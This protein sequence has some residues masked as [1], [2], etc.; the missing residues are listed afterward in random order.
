MKINKKNLF[1]FL[2]LLVIEI[3][4]ALFVHDNFIR[5]FVGDLIVVFLVYYFVKIFYSWNDTKVIIWVFLFAVFVEILQYFKL[6]EVLWI[7][8]RVLQIAIGSTFDIKDIVMYGLWCIILYIV[9]GKKIV[10][11]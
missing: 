6:I 8:N 3:I 2:L 1:I 5:P 10:K 4:I 11:K 9:S 7:E